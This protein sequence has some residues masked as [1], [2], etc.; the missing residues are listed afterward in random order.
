[1]NDDDEIFNAENCAPDRRSLASVSYRDRFL[2]TMCDVIPLKNIEWIYGPISYSEHVSPD[3]SKRVGIFGEVHNVPNYAGIN[4]R[5]T[6]SVATLLKI[7]LQRGDRFYDFFLERDYVKDDLVVRAETSSFNHFFEDCLKVVKN[8]SYANLRAHYID[9]RSILGVTY[10]WIVIKYYDL[11]HNPELYKTPYFTKGNL[12]TVMK[13]SLEYLGIWFRS[14]EKI[15]RMKENDIGAR[16]LHFINKEINARV[17]EFNVLMAKPEASQTFENAMMCMNT[18]MG[19]YSLWTDAYTLRRIFK[20]FARGRSPHQPPTADNCIVYVG[21]FHAEV[22][23]RFLS[24]ELNFT[25]T[26]NIYNNS[27]LLYFAPTLR[28]GLF[29]PTLRSGLFAPS[30]S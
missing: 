17:Q 24:E 11:I 6:V 10:R 9:Y 23:R 19:L 13:Q 25:M 3:G 21:Q 16:I 7:L 8:C 15:K 29:A 26:S 18:I 2:R 12:H 1:M 4:I 28:S 22:Y 14:A 5:N 30:L 20:T 27:S